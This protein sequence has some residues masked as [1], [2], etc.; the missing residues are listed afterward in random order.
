MKSNNIST[1]SCIH[2]PLQLILFWEGPP[3]F[4]KNRVTMAFIRKS[5]L[6]DPLEGSKTTEEL[7]SKGLS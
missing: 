5:V 6:K 4:T 3:I 1:I 2:Y 7:L